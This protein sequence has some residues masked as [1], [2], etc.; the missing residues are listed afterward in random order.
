MKLK[1][2]LQCILFSWSWN[3]FDLNNI[4]IQ[5]LNYSVGY[6]CW[7]CF[8]LFGEVFQVSISWEGRGPQKCKPFSPLLYTSK[9]NMK[10]YLHCKW[11]LCIQQVPFL[12]TYLNNF[13]GIYRVIS[14]H[15]A[16][17]KINILHYFT[18]LKIHIIVCIH[19]SENKILG[20]AAK[21][22]VVGVC[23]YMC[24]QCV[25]LCV[26]THALIYKYY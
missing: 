21:K 1:H 20:H 10:W 3:E 19:S 14:Y 25:S 12:R 17:K 15:P 4:V 26:H 6:C 9:Q 18:A 7:W 5:C 8:D 23:A 2:H 11:Y 24:V 22:E 13:T 16:I